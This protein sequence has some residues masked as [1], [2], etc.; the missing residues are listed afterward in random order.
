[1]ISIHLCLKFY[2]LWVIQPLST[3]IFI[4]VNYIEL[5]TRKFNIH[6]E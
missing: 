4:I 3:N 2:Y 1:M 5:I 6:T